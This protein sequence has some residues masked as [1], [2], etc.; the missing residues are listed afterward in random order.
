MRKTLSKE[1]CGYICMNW[2]KWRLQSWAVSWESEQVHAMRKRTNKV[3]N[4]KTKRKGKSLAVSQ[5]SITWLQK[6]N[7]DY[8]SF[9]CFRRT[10]S[11]AVGF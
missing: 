10:D 11:I 9:L 7:H 6:W 8:A 3:Q 4:S 1:N 2:N 5:F